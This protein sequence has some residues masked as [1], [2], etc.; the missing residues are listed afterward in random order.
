MDLAT[1]SPFSPQLN[2]NYVPSD[3]EVYELRNLIQ[4]HQVVIEDIN[5]QIHNTRNVY[6]LPVYG[7]RPP[8]PDPV[9]LFLVNLLLS[10]V[11]RWKRISF[12]LGI[13]SPDSPLIRLL[14]ASPEDL[15]QLEDIHIEP[16]LWYGSEILC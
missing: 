9:I 1:P 11:G 5:R 10:V 3:S 13:P 12:N 7:E 16:P 14:E 2:T 4:S 15:S 8:A 6:F